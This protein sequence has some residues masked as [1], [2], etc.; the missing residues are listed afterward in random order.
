MSVGLLRCCCVLLLFTNALELGD[1]E[2]CYIK[3]LGHL[4]TLKQNPINEYKRVSACASI[5]NIAG[6]VLYMVLLGNFAVL[7][8]QNLVM[9]KSVI[10]KL[11]VTLDAALHTRGQICN[12]CGSNRSECIMMMLLFSLALKLVGEKCYCK[13]LESID[14]S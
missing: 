7:S 5:Y 10:A 6:A 2:K 11:L 4:V 1:D 9:M 3:T 13:D 8:L 14:H 12:C